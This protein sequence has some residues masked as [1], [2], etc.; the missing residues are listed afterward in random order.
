MK[1][2]TLDIDTGINKLFSLSDG[3]FLGTDI[4]RLLTKLNRKV[5]GSKRYE[6]CLREIKHYIGQSANKIDFSTLDLVVM[7]NL[8]NITKN[9]KGRTNKTLRKQLGHWNIK[10]VFDRI[11]NKCELNR[12]WFELVN[13]QYT[14]QICSRCQVIDKTSKKGEIYECSHCGSIMDADTNAS[15]NILNKFLD[16]EPTVLYG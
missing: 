13:P 8:T 6:R 11:T 3:T 16:K 10:L 14:S 4:K 2:T 1:S 9:T 15:V 7:E 5:Q 12:V